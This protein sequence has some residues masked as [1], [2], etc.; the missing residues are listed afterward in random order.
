LLGFLALQQIVKTKEALM[1]QGASSVPFAQLPEVKALRRALLCSAG[2]LVVLLLVALMTTSGFN[3]AV[4]AQLPDWLTPMMQAARKAMFRADVWRSLG[5]VVAGGLV[6]YYYI[7]AEKFRST[8]LLAVVMGALVLFDMWPVD[9]RFM[10]DSMFSPSNSYEKQFKAQAWERQIL[11]AEG[12]NVEQPKVVTDNHFR[13]FNLAMNP[14]ND[15][16]TSY[17]L[18]SLGGYS[19]AKLRRYQD[20]ID[21]H[22]SK[23]H[24][25]VISMLNARYLVLPNQEQGGVTV[26]YNSQAMGNAWFVDS[27]VVANTPNEECDGLMKYDLSHVAVI[28]KDFASHAPA[29]LKA[30]STAS[31]RLTQYT[32]ESIEYDAQCAAPGVVVFS[33]VYYPYGW[34]A[35]VDGKPVEHY[36]VNYILRALNLEAGKHHI[37]FEFRPESVSKGNTISMVFVVLMLLTIVGCIAKGVM[38]LRKN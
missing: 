35:L 19:A 6:L 34:N 33:E 5:F 1:A 10:N 21:Q 24:L 38:D 8:A 4:D 15:A 32:P 36:R 29:V 31:V 14:F 26:Q 3:G 17:R 12:M 23:M 9:K 13:V 22:L 16:R 37:R 27:L 28:G 11:E 20:L 18:K 7:G 25:P 30:D 2:I